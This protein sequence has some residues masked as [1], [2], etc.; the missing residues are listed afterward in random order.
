LDKSKALRMAKIDFI[1]EYSPNPYFWSAFILS[2]NT[3]GI[4]LNT[5]TSFLP[6][7]IGLTL[8]AAAVFLFITIKKKKQSLS[9]NNLKVPN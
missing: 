7:Y 2:G 9:K 8:A 6:Y 4:S 3:E 1:N 5:P